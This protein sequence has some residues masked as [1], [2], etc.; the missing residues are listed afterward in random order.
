M[1]LTGR[2]SFNLRSVSSNEITPS[3]APLESRMRISPERKQAAISVVNRLLLT[4]EY[5][6]DTPRL[7]HLLTVPE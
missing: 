6:L 3:I 1:L 5:R 7:V 4:Q 2:H